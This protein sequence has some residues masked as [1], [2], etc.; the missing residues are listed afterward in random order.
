MKQQSIDFSNRALN[1]KEFK[2]LFEKLQKVENI[3]KISIA[4][5]YIEK[6]KN[7]KRKLD[8]KFD[9]IQELLEYIKYLKKID[10]IEVCF[11]TKSTTV[12]LLY[13]D[14]TQCWRLEYSE[15]NNITN[16][17]IYILNNYFKPNFIK[18]LLFFKTNI[19]W[20]ILLGYAIG[21]KISLKNVVSY[22]LVDEIAVCIF[23]L[24]F[25]AMTGLC[26]YI[27]IR[28]KRPYKNNRFWEI[29]KIEIIQNTI[30]YILGVVTPYIITWI[31]SKIK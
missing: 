29:H 14:F 27:L 8:K 24:L 5:T 2:E 15:E 25:V 23:V 12:K 9:S 30:F 22:T 16:S 7:T 31:S 20:G 4:I 21:L 11:F 1:Y 17:I 10:K 19:L 6:K 3:D 26:I 18:T 13:D 28:R